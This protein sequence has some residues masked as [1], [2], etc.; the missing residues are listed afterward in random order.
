M[1]TADQGLFRKEQALEFLGAKKN[2][3][4]FELF[5][6]EQR[7]RVSSLNLSRT[8]QLRSRHRT[9][10]ANEESVMQGQITKYRDDLGFGVIKTD[11]GRRY[12]FAKQQIRSAA[13]VLIGQDVDFV[14]YA[15]HPTEI[16]VLAGTPWSAFGRLC[17]GE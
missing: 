11:D 6:T 2:L 4:A 5:R 14:L 9:A 7:R 3:N 17:G 15:S 13:D 8:T 12:R 1:E 10:A 16:I